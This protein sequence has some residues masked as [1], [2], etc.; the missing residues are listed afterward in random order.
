MKMYIGH[1][2]I[3]GTVTGKSDVN[4]EYLVDMDVVCESMDGFELVKG[5]AQVQLP[6]RT[7][8]KGLRY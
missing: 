6:S 5:T 8:F 7:D 1:G 2:K 3:K 4:G